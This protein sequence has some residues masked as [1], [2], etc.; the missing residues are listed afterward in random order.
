MLKRAVFICHSQ[1]ESAWKDRLAALLGDHEVVSQDNGGESI[2]PQRLRQLE[3]SMAA[4]HAAVFLVS[5]DF[6]TAP[7]IRDVQIP[8]LCRLRDE[9]RL[10]V[11]PVLVG[12]C[13]WQG[14]AWLDG[15]QMRTA[16]GE[17]LAGAE[18]SRAYQ[19]LETLAQDV[20]GHLSNGESSSDGPPPEWR[21]MSR[22]ERFQRL[23]QDYY[24]PVVY[25][26]S[27]RGI[28][29][30]EC[31]DLTQETFQK[32]YTGM[33]DFREE[34]SPKTWLLKIALNVW[35][36]RQRRTAT[37]KRNRPV[38]SIHSA[39]EDQP[40]LDPPDTE[41]LDPQARLLQTERV[42]LVRDALAKLSPQRRK[43]LVLRLEGLKYREIAE[44]LGIS[45]QSV[46]SHLFQAREQLRGIL[47]D[48][49]REEDF[50]DDEG[51]DDE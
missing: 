13:N 43:S 25:F 32:V 20:E 47:G 46:R 44:L 9:G 7:L 2:T 50:S 18:E 17:P 45:L 36:N 22:D 3:E 1:A 38:V 8:F 35:H 37:A 16:A 42:K 24:R 49:F 41:S 5:K 30:D 29:K 34:A 6:L 28:P 15:L 26:F 48:R 31:Q 40:A 14:A 27:G 10:E 33:D 51:E 19:L 39:D 23:F 12:S 4:A 11:F 21:E